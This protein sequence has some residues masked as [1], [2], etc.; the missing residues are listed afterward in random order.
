MPSAERRT[1]QLAV[2]DDPDRRLRTPVR[3]VQHEPAAFLGCATLQ[4]KGESDR[5][6]FD[7]AVLGERSTGNELGRAVHE[8]L[9]LDRDRGPICD[10][11]LERV[12][13][14][15]VCSQWGADDE[16]KESAESAETSRKRAD[17]R[18]IVL[19]RG[20]TERERVAREVADKEVHDM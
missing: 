14:G 17:K 16:S 18:A 19:F 1:A 7:D 6:T 9:L 3:R 2:S 5:R 11:I 13:V 8:A 15:D 4:T 10:G 12:D 20:L